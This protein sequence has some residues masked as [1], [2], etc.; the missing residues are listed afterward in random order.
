MLLG[1]DA[2]EGSDV[3]RTSEAD[4]VF[5]L[6]KGTHAAYARSAGLDARRAAS[7]R[8]HRGVAS[9]SSRVGAV[10]QR[11][12]AIQQGA[13]G[14]SAPERSAARVALRRRSPPSTT[15]RWPRPQNR[16]GREEVNLSKLIA[17]LQ[18]AA[19][20]PRPA[21]RLQAALGRDRACL[22]KTFGFGKAGPIFELHCPM[23]FQGQGARLVS[24]QPM[25]CEIRITAKRC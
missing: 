12:L 18:E 16:L 4:R 2:V 7:R 14:R 10:W 25:K 23:A 8:A 22:A 21:N 11:Y 17:S 19:R 24:G 15:R 9:V 1:N 5:L 13:G 3:M 20:Y 6:L